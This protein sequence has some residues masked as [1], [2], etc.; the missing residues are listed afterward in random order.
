MKSVNLKQEKMKAA[1]K[2]KKYWQL[3][4]KYFNIINSSEN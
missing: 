1:E 3:K 2:L 4:L